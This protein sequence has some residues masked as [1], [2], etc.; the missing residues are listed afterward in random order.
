[1]AE[2]KRAVELA[3]SAA[4]LQR[5]GDELQARTNPVY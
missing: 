3:A 5:R 2:A 4:E 1:M